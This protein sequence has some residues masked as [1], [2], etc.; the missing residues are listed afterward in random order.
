M[1][2]WIVTCL[3]A[4]LMV[5]GGGRAPARDLGAEIAAVIDGSTVAGLDWSAVVENADGTVRYFERN[6]ELLLAPASNT[7]LFTSA[8]AFG[9]LGPTHAFETLVYT[10]GTLAGG[11]LT[12]NL[13]AVVFHDI[14]WNTSTFSSARAP[15]D[16]IA[17][18]VRSAGITAIT[19]NVRVFG[20]T[21]YNKSSTDDIRN[22]AV[23]TLNGESAT[24]FVDALRTAGVTVAGVAQGQ[25]GFTAPGT[26]LLTYRSSELNTIYGVPADLSGASYAVNRPSHNP[27]ADLLLRALAYN[28]TAGASNT[29]ADGGRA[30][31]QWLANEAGINMTGAVSADGSGLSYSNRFSARQTVDLLRYM[32]ANYPTYADT[33]AIACQSGTLSGRLCGTETTRRVLGKTGTL[34]ISI[35]VSGLVNSV[36]GNQRYYFSFLVNGPPVVD[37]ATIRSTIDSAIRVIATRAVP[38]APAITSV[39]PVANGIAV[40]WQNPGAQDVYT[41]ERRVGRGPWEP[42]ITV[43]ALQVIETRGDL[44]PARNTNDFTTTGIFEPSSAHSTAPGT[45]PGAGSLFARPTANASIRFTPRVASGRYEVAVTCYNVASADARGITVRLADAGGVRATTIDLTA[46]TAGDRWLVLGEIDVPA[47]GGAYVE[48]DNSTQTNRTDNARM[49]PAAVRL[50]RLG[51]AGY[52]RWVDT[53]APLGEVVS[54]RIRGAAPRGTSTSRPSN[55]YTARR[56]GAPVRLLLVD[57]NER[58]AAQPQPENTNVMNHEF[59][60]TVGLAMPA[61]VPFG[62]ASARALRNNRLRLADFAAVSWHLGE[63]STV[64][65]TFSAAEQTLV[66][67]WLD[68]G[69]ALSVSGAEL[70]WDLGAQGIPADRAFLSNYLRVTY[71]ADGSGTTNVTPSG[72]YSGL[73]TLSFAGGPMVIDW[74]DVLTPGQG[75]TTNLVYTG[76][77]GGVAGIEYDGTWKL[78]VAGFPIEMISGDAALAGVM[79]RQVEFLLPA[80]PVVPGSF[81][82]LF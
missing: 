51:D 75:A 38:T 35:C 47:A 24:A 81:W 39:M 82:M 74:A 76:G 66:A 78:L 22:T 62:S 27:A 36:Y 52:V 63:E 65:E 26:L 8:A 1:R 15:L 10:E 58:W 25:S 44:Q 56:T 42:A 2:G 11:T 59:L 48:F 6:P 61:G 77:T 79:A 17:A 55:V 31:I 45:T 72:I 37:Q 60:G 9:L 43:P 46:T 12:G 21:A 70:A 29:L 54:Y 64:D 4:L 3:A 53:T 73:G 71:A 16:R 41:L 28:T 57:G 67:A 49:N 14:S 7:K 19:G 68:A 13:N 80:E 23:T 32:V 40:E 33:L 18:R 30:V 5:L 20:Y 50:R 69:G 34:N